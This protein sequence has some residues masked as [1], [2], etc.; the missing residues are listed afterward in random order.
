MAKG[1]VVLDTAGQKVQHPATLHLW[2]NT[3][4]I[5]G[6]CRNEKSSYSDYFRRSFEKELA[7]EYY[8]IIVSSSLDTSKDRRT[9]SEERREMDG[10]IDKRIH[11]LDARIHAYSVSP[12][13]LFL[14][15]LIIAIKLSSTTILIYSVDLRSRGK[16]I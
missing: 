1:S 11:K 10:F 5:I 3:V 9:I 6:T 16:R 15:Q 13:H 14:W 4:Q 12:N 8:I 2:L 7:F